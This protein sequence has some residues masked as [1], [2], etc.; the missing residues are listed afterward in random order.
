MAQDPI[1]RV[2]AAGSIQLGPQAPAIMDRIPFGATTIGVFVPTGSATYSLE[3]T[4]DYLD[5]D[6]DRSTVPNASARWF[7]LDDMPAGTTGN[8][9]S[10]VYYPFQAMRLNITQLTDTVEFKILM[11]TTGRW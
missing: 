11:S 1:L 3:F 5:I 7:T 10:V 4:L 6:T 2:Y 8:Q 9:Y